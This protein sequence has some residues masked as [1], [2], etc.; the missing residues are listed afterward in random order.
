MSGIHAWTGTNLLGS[1]G[2]AFLVVVH[3]GMA[4]STAVAGSDT[5]SLLQRPISYLN[6]VLKSATK[7]RA[8]ISQWEKTKTKKGSRR[9]TVTWRQRNHAV[10]SQCSD[11][12]IYM[13][14]YQ[15]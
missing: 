7:N 13:C 6:L 1:L 10:L 5:N 15:K 2:G 8:D 12:Y 3:G 11:V 9:S 14:V 4:Q